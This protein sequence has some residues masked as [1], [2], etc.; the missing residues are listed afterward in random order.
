VGV[1]SGVVSQHLILRSRRPRL[2]SGRGPQGSEAPVLSARS[3]VS[4][5][6]AIVRL[7]TISS[8]VLRGLLQA[9]CVPFGAEV[10]LDPKSWVVVV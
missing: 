4:V 2:L 8:A 3:A 5:V 6:Q 7:R 9:W 1:G 10:V